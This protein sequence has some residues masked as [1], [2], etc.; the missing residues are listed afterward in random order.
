MH[1][2]FKRDRRFWFVCYTCMMQTG[3]DTEKSVFYSEGEPVAIL[4]RPWMQCPRC[5]GTNTKSFEELKREGSDSAVFG[6]ERLV[7]KFPR[8]HFEVKPAEARATRSRGAT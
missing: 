5:L 4:G 6:L 1:R 3:H 7:K 2:W 8:S